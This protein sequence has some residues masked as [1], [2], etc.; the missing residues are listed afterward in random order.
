MSEK[1]SARRGSNWLLDPINQLASLARQHEVPQ[2]IAVLDA[3]AVNALT[4]GE[5]QQFRQLCKKISSGE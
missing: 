3:L 5:L 2:A 4:P 1:D